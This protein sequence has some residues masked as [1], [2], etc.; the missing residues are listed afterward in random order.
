MP[1]KTRSPV[2]AAVFDALKRQAFAANQ[3]LPEYGLISLTFGNASVLDRDRGVLA[4]KPSGIAYAD[5]RPEDMVLLDL[6][7]SPVEQAGLRPSSDTSTHICL[8]RAFP[9]VRAVVHTH[10][11]AATAFAQAEMAVPCLG[12]THA[13]YFRGEI[14]VTGPLS[15]AQIDGDYE[16][17][18][19]NAIV[20]RFAELDPSERPGVLVARHGPFAWGPDGARA[21][22]SAY[23]ME[24]LAEMA[25]AT[26]CLRPN[27]SPMP[28]A[29]MDRHFS[30]KHG[31]TAYY[32][33]AP[34]A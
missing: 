26:L 22:E 31:G 34:R 18:T 5:L 2:E 17:E 1:V 6:E 10:S 23:A 8:Y 19:G 15:P 24:L 13:D 16:W 12:T 7:G 9:S 29:L 14:P 32:G 4:I 20:A 30:R 25:L 33:Q 27:Q 3:L 28:A 21:A 11:R